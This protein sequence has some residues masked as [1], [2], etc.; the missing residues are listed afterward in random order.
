[1][2]NSKLSQTYAKH[3][4]STVDYADYFSNTTG[5]GKS[6]SSRKCG[7]KMSARRYYN[8]RFNLPMKMR[9]FD[10][11]FEMVGLEDNLGYLLERKHG[12]NNQNS[13]FF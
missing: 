6:G 1:M 10:Q 4:N 7:L 5:F 2:K 8:M 13:Q 12:L 11:L 3:F 9:Y